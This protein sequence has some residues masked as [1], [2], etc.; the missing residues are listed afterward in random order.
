MSSGFSLYNNDNF[1][2]NLVTFSCG[3]VDVPVEVRR[4]ASSPV[5]PVDLDEVLYDLRVD[6]ADEPAERDSV[7]RMFRTAAGYIEKASAC[8]VCRGTFEALLP[9]WWDGDLEVRRYPLREVVSIEG[10]TAANTWAVVPDAD[11]YA[12]PGADAFRVRILNSYTRP[13]LWSEV[14]RTRLRFEA[15]FDDAAGSGVSSGADTGLPILD[16]FKG[17]AIAMT[18]HLYKNRELLEADRMSEVERGL[19]S[20][21]GSIRTLW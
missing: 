21:L 18:A 12:E 14:N 5:L 16:P 17:I 2:R 10:L 3:G 6:D 13:T 19:G 9:G 7:E 4:I 15:G 11:L 8:V 20:L 1:I